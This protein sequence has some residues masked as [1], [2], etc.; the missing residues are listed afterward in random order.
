MSGLRKEVWIKQILKNYYTDSSFLKYTKDFSP[1]V[2]NDAIN[3][4]EAGVDPTV[5]INNS[6]YPINIY[7]RV[8]NPIRIELDLFETENTLVRYPEAIEYSYDQLESVIMGHRNTLRSATAQKA[9]HAFAPAGDTTET[10]VIKTTGE[11]SSD[12]I[13]KRMKIVDIL[14]M[15]ERFDAFDVPLEDRFLVLHPFHLTD[16]ILE[17]TKVFKDITD[18]VNGMPKRFAGFNILQFSKPAT[19]D[20]I[21]MQKKSFGAVPGAND[22]FCSFAY[23]KEEVMKADG[24]LKMYRRDNDPEERGTIVGFDKRFIA[25]PI[26]NKAVGAIVSALVQ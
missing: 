22:T 17:D 24:A 11:A 23:Y 8:D 21:T 16:L 10:P 7:Q 12:G 3:L 18:I 26:R 6:T 14:T 4:A 19:Y 13:R 2:E 5:L 15:K 25:L 9:A 20:F 1:L